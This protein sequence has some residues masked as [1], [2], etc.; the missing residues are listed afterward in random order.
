V[1]AAAS[2]ATPA[3]LGASASGQRFPTA[4]LSVRTAGAAT[5]EPY[6]TITL[7]DA[8]VTSFSEDAAGGGARP[9]DTLSLD[10]ARLQVA[11]RAQAPDGTLAPP[12][13]T[14]W[15]VRANASCAQ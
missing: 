15:D 11:Y 2:R 3:L 9:V 4:V 6:L 10:Y 13:V 12:V 5:G 7:T 14:C 1:K 8:S